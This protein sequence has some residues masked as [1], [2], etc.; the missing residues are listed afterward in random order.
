ML[1]R[2][3]KHGEHAIYNL[4]TARQKL[5]DILSSEQV[6]DQY[7]LSHKLDDF[8]RDNIRFFAFLAVVLDMPAKTFQELDAAADFRIA[9]EQPIKDDLKHNTRRGSFWHDKG[10]ED[11]IRQVKRLQKRYNYHFSPSDPLSPKSLSSIGRD[12]LDIKV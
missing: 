5:F 1:G 9:A 3:G 8:F 10:V 4:R 7:D 6:H 2:L 11:F 12:G